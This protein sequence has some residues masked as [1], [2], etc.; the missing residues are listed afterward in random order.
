MGYSIVGVSK[1]YCLS[2]NIPENKIDGYMEHTASLSR[3]FSYKH[4][5]LRLQA[6]VANLTNEQYDVIKYYPM[7]GRSWRITGT[8]KF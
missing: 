5:K 6:E 4:Y 7:P 2:Q 3:E 1:R 8:F